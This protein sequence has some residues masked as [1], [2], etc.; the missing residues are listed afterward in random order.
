M[1]AGLPSYKG[2]VE[3]CYVELGQPLPNKNSEDWLWPDR[4]LGALENICSPED[5]RRVA[6]EKLSEK[7]KSLDFHKALLRLAR[8]RKNEGLRLVTTN[9]DLLF[10]KTQDNLRLGQD[11]HSGP[12]L[13]IPRNDKI[14]SW[15]SI[16][17]LH[18]RLEPPNKDNSHLVLTSADFGRAYL[19][20]AWAARFVNRLFSDFTVLFIGYSL[21]DPVLRYMTDAFA[22]E[23]A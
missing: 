1:G 7:P 19:T 16:V 11:F 23:D 14:V 3:H 15:R 17:Y 5:V 10:E 18:G 13:P 4:M 22:A 2:L 20:D 12:V 6:V 8:L 9:F 21:N